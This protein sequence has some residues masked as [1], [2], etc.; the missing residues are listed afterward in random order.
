MCRR[1]HVAV[2]MAEG[3]RGRRVDRGRFLLPGC[4][5]N[6]GKKRLLEEVHGAPL[7]TLTPGPGGGGHMPDSPGGQSGPALTLT[8]LPPPPVSS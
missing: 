2:W 7:F 3:G 6:G 8:S 5:T 1:R 4:G